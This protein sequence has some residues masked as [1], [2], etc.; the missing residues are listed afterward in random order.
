MDQ[1]TTKAE[2]RALYKR[3]REL[4]RQLLVLRQA[5]TIME[6]E[7][8]SAHARKTVGTLISRLT[9]RYIEARRLLS[10]LDIGQP[11]KLAARLPV[12]A[13]KNEAEE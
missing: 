9:T 2:R 7:G 11:Q 10:Y 1:T 12:M 4:L 6:K 8:A 3:T 13:E 5:L